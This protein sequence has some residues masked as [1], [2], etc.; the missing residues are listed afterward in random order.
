MN[1]RRTQAS[2]WTGM[3]LASYISAVGI[4]MYGRRRVDFSTDFTYNKYHF[5]V[6]SNILCGAGYMLS[7]KMV[8][9]IQAG[10]CFHGA[11]IFLS[12]PGMYEGYKDIHNDPWEEDTSTFRKFGFFCLLGGY[13]V[14]WKKY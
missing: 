5:S 2:I 1:F 8:V 10:M 7:S 4:G 13:A 14:I 6:F 12:L 3:S 9:P 11:I